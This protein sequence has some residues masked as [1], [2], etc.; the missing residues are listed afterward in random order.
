MVHILQQVLEGISKNRGIDILSKE[1][2]IHASKALVFNEAQLDAALEYFDKLKSFLY[3]PNILPDVVFTNAQVPLDKLSELVR[4]RHQLQVVKVDPTRATDEP[5]PGEWEIFRDHGILCT[6]LLDEL[7]R[8]HVKGF[9]Q[10]R[11][12]YFSLKSSSL[13]P[14]LQTMNIF[15]CNSRCQ[16][17]YRDSQLTRDCTS[18]GDVPQWLGPSWCL[19]LYCVLPHVPGWLED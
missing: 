18:S 6:S 9:L 8:H 14:N 1:D 19:L 11:D 5:C 3:K 15:S 7:P 4:K 12:L 2:C 16:R 17:G 13:F 10:R